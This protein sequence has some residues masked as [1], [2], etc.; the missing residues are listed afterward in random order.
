MRRKKE[1]KSGG[2]GGGGEKKGEG[3]IYLRGVFLSLVIKSFLDF[4]WESNW[5]VSV[6]GI[7]L[8]IISQWLHHSLVKKRKEELAF[9]SSS[10][11]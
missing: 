5:K 4:T 2:G 9:T 11:T 7:P 3:R 1:K 8:F 6:N 10:E